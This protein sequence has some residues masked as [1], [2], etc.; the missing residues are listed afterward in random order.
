MLAEN[1]DLAKQRRKKKSRWTND[2]E[3]EGGDEDSTLKTSDDE[4]NLSESHRHRE[5]DTPLLDDE[6]VQAGSD[7][8][9]LDFFS[10]DLHLT[11]QA[12]CL[13][14]ETKSH[15]AL[16]FLDA[17]ARATFGFRRGKI[18]YEFRIVDILDCPQMPENEKER[19][20]VRLGWSNLRQGLQ[21]LQ[22]GEVN[23]SF[24]YASSGKKFRRVNDEFHEENYGET[25]TRDDV[26]A[27]YLDLGVDDEE[28]RSIRVS[29]TKN[30][31]DLGTAFEYSHQTFA[32]QT[33]ST[34]FYPHILVKNVK[35]QCNFGQSVSL[36][37]FSRWRD[38]LFVVCLGISL[39]ADESGFHLCSTNSARRT[40]SSLRTDQREKRM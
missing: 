19:F 4:E 38:E 5:R 9:V 13:A 17:G 1:D 16:C 32:E 21:A 30:G 34:I 36:Q 14:A 24:A 22:L 40:R 35:F 26:L 12:D 23:D 2:V 18:F 29:F 7:D 10:S 6:L 37:R 27:C 15:D 11:F 20:S 31:E 28:N 25:F 3:G 39:G 8:V 33:N